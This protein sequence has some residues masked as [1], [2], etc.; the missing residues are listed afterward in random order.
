MDTRS[1]TR[2][3]KGEISGLTGLL[4]PYLLSQ[5]TEPFFIPTLFVDYS[6]WFDALD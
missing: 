3:L 2:S 4:I 1:P 5:Q 6:S